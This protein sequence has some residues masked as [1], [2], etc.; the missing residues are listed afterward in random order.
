MRLYYSM[1]QFVQIS[2]RSRAEGMISSLTTM[3]VIIGTL[4]LFIVWFVLN[5]NNFQLQT[6]LNLSLKKAQIEGY[7]SSANITQTKNYLSSVGLSSATVTSPQMAAP[8]GYGSEIQIIITTS[9]MPLPAMDNTGHA[10]PDDSRSTSL[11]ATGY[12]ISQYVP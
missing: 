11:T 10:V 12:I 7:L 8:L 4:A 6:A 9:S 1:S 2:K 5:A 3:V